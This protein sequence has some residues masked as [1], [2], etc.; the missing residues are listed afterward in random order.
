MS[1]AVSHASS[2]GGDG[3]QAPK[4]PHSIQALQ[5][6]AI[7][8]MLEGMERESHMESCTS[9]DINCSKEK[10]LQNRVEKSNELLDSGLITLISVSSR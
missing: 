8:E 7:V 1:S 5:A 3:Q 2:A 10:T 4:D 9:R 6:C